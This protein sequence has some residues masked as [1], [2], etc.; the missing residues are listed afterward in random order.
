MNAKKRFTMEEHC[1]MA[2]MLTALREE[3]DVR[4]AQIA[5]AYPKTSPATR[6]A[7]S[8]LTALDRL[9]A[10]L[11]TEVLKENPYEVDKV[12]LPKRTDARYRLFLQ[13]EGER[14]GR[15]PAP[16][17]VMMAAAWFSNLNWLMQRR[18]IEVINSEEEMAHVLT[19]FP[20]PF[21]RDGEWVF[22]IKG[23]VPDPWKPTHLDSIRAYLVTRPQ[24]KRVQKNHTPW[25]DLTLEEHF[26][27]KAARRSA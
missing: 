15:K 13:R 20:L 9:R 25:T 22:P 27:A 12:Y 6:N 7:Q 8:A 2:G 24:L 26:A 23:E 3:L 11:D 21:L 1:E 19:W 17:N 14:E 16:T 18:V 5:S 4:T 10:V